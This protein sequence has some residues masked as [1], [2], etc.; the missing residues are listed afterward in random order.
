MA[1]TPNGWITSGLFFSWLANCFSQE[2]K[3]QVQFPIVVFMDG[4]SSHINVAVGEFC[5]RIILFCFP[6][7]AS[8][9]IRTLD[10]CI[11]GPLKKTWNSEV[12][13][14]QN[15][16]KQMMVQSNF[17]KVFDKAWDVCVQKPENIRS[18]FRKAGLI[19]F[20]LNALDYSRLINEKEAAGDLRRSVSVSQVNADQRLGVM[21]A[22]KYF[23]QYLHQNTMKIL[24]ERYE[25]NYDITDDTLLEQVSNV[26]KAIRLLIDPEQINE[27]HVDLRNNSISLSS[28]H[29]E[30]EIGT[31]HVVDTDSSYLT[32][33]SQQII[34]ISE[35][36][37]S[38]SC[39]RRV[40]C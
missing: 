38:D 31:M 20:D 22:I 36:D 2:V 3:Y 26:Y 6:P 24:K 15:Q 40:N 28:M 13:N 33:P 21:R 32:D 35:N 11:W 25:E 12:R 39:H 8:H 17:I 18:G 1:M 23:D 30:D 29:V 27:S 10:I 5:I 9:V 7:H 19:P 37:N 4:H 14:F 16:Y 34:E